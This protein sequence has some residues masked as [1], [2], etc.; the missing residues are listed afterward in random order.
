MKNFDLKKYL[1]E[2]KLLN[3]STP[4]YDTR[5]S[6]EALPTLESV[7]A[8]YE[9]KNKKNDLKESLGFVEL[10]DVEG[11]I[12]ELV[13]AFDIWKEGPMTEPE[14]I[15]P[16]KKD[17]MDYVSRQLDLALNVNKELS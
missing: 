2:G 12:E 16:A 9:A 8:A 15:I 7:K 17:L 4:G 3:E 13:N 11:P 6:G 5:K 14:D 1:A 10:M